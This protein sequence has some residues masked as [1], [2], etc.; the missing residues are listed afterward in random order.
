MQLWNLILKIFIRADLHLQ[1]QWWWSHVNFNSKIKV[2][3]EYRSL[4][5]IWD[6]YTIS[7]QAELS[8]L[9]GYHL[10][11]YRSCWVKTIARVRIG[12]IFWPAPKGGTTL[13]TFRLWW[14]MKAPNCAVQCVV[15]QRR[16]R[17]GLRCGAF[18]GLHGQRRI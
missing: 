7:T 15:R 6:I 11:C 18:I 10:H 13:N 4:F 2:E 3:E 8:M 14:P 9:Y 5:Q 17:T 16:Q 1:L 12:S